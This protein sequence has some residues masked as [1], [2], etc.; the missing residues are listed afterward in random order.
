M[1]DR[2]GFEDFAAKWR[3]RWPEWAIAEVFAP[4][5]QRDV[6]AAWFTLLQEF[7]DAMNIA[8]DPLP[9]DAKLA[10]WGEELRDWSRQRSRHPLG[11][12][13]ESQRAP[14]FELAEALPA[15]VRL[16]EQPHDAETAFDTLRPLAAAIIGVESAL[17]GHESGEAE[18]RTVSAQW[19]AA[20]L[21]EAGNAAVPF[22]MAGHADPSQAD[23]A[24]ELQRQWPGSGGLPRRLWSALARSRLQRFR[25]A[26]EGIT[27]L[28]PVRALWL[29]WRAARRR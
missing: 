26:G 8:G 13:L 25:A 1:S 12:V 23:W 27:P 17:F 28:S 24:M 6:A 3:A 18:L 29:G 4:A 10:W 7:V 5:A 9:A 15:L 22:R 11:R 2:T 19:L 21:E 14:W 20:R 16:R